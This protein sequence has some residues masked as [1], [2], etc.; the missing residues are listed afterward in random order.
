MQRMEPAS[1]IGLGRPVKRMLQSSN[2]VI[3]LPR[4]G[5]RRSRPGPHRGGT[6]QIGTHR[7]P[8]SR[9]YARNEAAALP[10]PAVL[11]S[12]RLD[13]Y[14]DRLR[15]PPGTSTTSRL[16]TGYRH[17]PSTPRAGR[18]DRGGSPQFPPSPSQRS[19]PSTPRSP[20]RLPFQDLHRFH[21]LHR[22][23][24]GSALPQC[25]T[26]RQAS[27][28]LRTAELLPPKGLSTL[29]SDPTRFQTE[30]PACYRASWQLPGPDSHR[31]ATTSFRPRH[32]RKA[33]T[34]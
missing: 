5:H 18:F 10:S 4:R 28:A 31:Q 21:G 2:R 20:S 22:E 26:T 33:T 3:R 17:Q 6:S 16:H 23:R 29:G 15:L 30:P 12:A 7:A 8:P 32:G 1:R 14:Y 13:Q 25:L 27:L 19:A 11:L 34:S 24:P 9:H